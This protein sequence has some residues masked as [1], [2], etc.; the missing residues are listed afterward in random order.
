[1]VYIAAD[2]DRRYGYARIP[3]HERLLANSIRW[4]WGEGENKVFSSEGEGYIDCKLYKQENRWILHTV[5]LS[6]LNMW[7]GYAEEHYTVGPNHFRVYVGD[8]TV[9]NVYGTNEHESVPFVQEGEWVTF[10]LEHLKFHDMIV[11]E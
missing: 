1:M 5:N 7:P 3:D 11:I 10:T 4:A 8:Q 2:I 6:G 9:K